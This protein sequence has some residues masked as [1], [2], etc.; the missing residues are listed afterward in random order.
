MSKLSPNLKPF[1]AK[2][3]QDLV[4]LGE[5]KVATNRAEAKL[6]EDQRSEVTIRGFT[7]IQDEPKSVLGSGEGPTPTDFFMAS[8]ALCENVVFARN[9]ALNDVSIGSLETVATG[10]WD[11]R[12]LFEAGGAEPSFSSVLVETR[13][14]SDSPLA[15]VVNVARMTHRRCPVHATLRKATALTFRLVVNGTE[16][17]L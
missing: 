16:A 17:P 7:F 5:P 14:K 15:E 4:A 8:V 11:M 10:T 6:E 9:A 2:M 12:G 1:F 13:V 3:A